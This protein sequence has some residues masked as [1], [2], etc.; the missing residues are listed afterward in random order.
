MQSLRAMHLAVAFIDPEAGA[1]R[2]RDLYDAD[3]CGMI[4]NPIRRLLKSVR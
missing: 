4:V 2:R 1:I 3:D